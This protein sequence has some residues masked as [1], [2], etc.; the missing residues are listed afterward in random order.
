MNT[1]E[2]RL[3]F[4][5]VVQVSGEDAAVFLHNQLSND[6]KN[7]PLNDA[8][9]A[10]YN[11]P[12]GRVLANML[13]LRHEAGFLLIMA[14]DLCETIISRLEKYILR[15]KVS[16]SLEREYVV[17]GCLPQQAKLFEPVTRLPA[18]QLDKTLWQIYLPHGGYFLVGQENKNHLPIADDQQIAKWTQHE[19]MAGFPWIMAQTSGQCV[20]QMLNLHR[21]GAVHFKKG[22]YPGQ[23]VIAR[24]QYLGQVKRGLVVLSAPIPFYNADEITNE[25]GED[26]GL[27][28]NVVKVVDDYQAIA[29]IR[30]DAANRPLMVRQQS[31]KLMTT[32]FD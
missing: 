17:A 9:Y 16:L 20:A 26:V 30:Y 31:V 21:T 27:V 28:I 8:A 22:C 24:A 25:S 19:I 1:I 4:F 32:F 5:G 15:S 3:P 10:S 7:L 29:V 18:S 14:A 13:V 2:T 12:Q 6:M 23:E 11:T